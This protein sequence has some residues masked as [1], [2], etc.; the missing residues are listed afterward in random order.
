[1]IQRLSRKQSQ[2]VPTQEIV[3]MLKKST[4]SFGISCMTK[5]HPPW[6]FIVDHKFHLH[7][8]HVHEYQSFKLNEI[9]TIEHQN[10]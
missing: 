1:M 7:I 3:N 2:N 6:K 5:S 9:A 10:K 4:M 8:K